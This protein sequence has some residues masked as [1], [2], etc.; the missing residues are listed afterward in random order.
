MNIYNKKKNEQQIK[1]RK[2][3]HDLENV[4]KSSR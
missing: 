1:K 3:K 4:L 2:K